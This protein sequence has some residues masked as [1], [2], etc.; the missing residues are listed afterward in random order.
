MS[1][2]QCSTA[3]DPADWTELR[4]QGHRMLDDMFDHLQGLR[5]QPVW[6]APPDDLRLDYRTAAPRGP[7]ALAEVHARFMSDIAPYSSGNAHPG[8]MGWVQGG[9][10]PVGMLAEMLAAGLNANL[11]GRDHMPIEVE[12][13]VG[14]WMSEVFGFPS[15]AGGLFLTGT[16]QA[17]FCAVLAARSR[18]LGAAVRTDG[19]GEDGRRLTAYVSR[20]AHGC[21]ARAMEMS[22]LGSGALRLIETD[23]HDRIDLS[24]LRRAIAADRAAGKTPFL[25]IGTAGTVGIGAID[26]LHGLADIAKANGIPFHVD[27]AFGALAILSPDLAPRLAG[28]ERADSLAFDFHKWGQVPYDAGYLLVRDEA[29]LRRTFAADDAYLRRAGRGLAGGDWWPCDLGPDLSRGFR[30]LK[31]WFTLR[32]YGLDAIGASIAATCSL[33]Q[34]LAQ[35]IESSPELELLAPVQLNIVCF[36]YRGRD[37]DRLNAQ[38]VERLQEGGRVAPSL[39]VV[40]GRTAIRAAIVNHRT[41]IQDIEALVAE[42]LALGRAA[43]TRTA[44][45]VVMKVQPPAPAPV[46]ATARITGLAVFAQMVFDGV[47]LATVWGGLVERAI[48]EPADPGALLDL[49]MILQLTG[50]AEQ[51]LNIQQQALDLTRLYRRQ[52]GD[53]SGPRILALVTAGDFMANTPLD[54]LLDGSDVQLDYL[55][56]SEDAPLPERLPEHD[57]AFFAVGE[58]SANR[59]TLAAMAPL[60][61]AWPRPMLNGDPDRI[62]ALTRDGVCAMSAAIPQVLSPVVRRL[63]R[64]DLLAIAGRHAELDRYLPGASFP[65]IIRPIDS[66]AGKALSKL[67]TAAQLAAYLDVQLQSAFYLTQFVDYAGADGLYRKQRIAFIDGQPFISHMAISEHWMVHYLNA[68]MGER[69]ERRDEEARFMAAFDQDFAV[70]HAEAF[71]AL[72]AA[73]GLDYFAIDCGETRDGR[74]LLFEADVAMIVH[75]MDSET[76][77][78]YKRPAMRKLL[79]RFQARLTEAAAVPSGFAACVA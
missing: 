26:D 41:E 55:Y 70:R 48:A 2:P 51:G 4:L 42:T 68:G 25:V 76:V 69:P 38:I 77:Y 46:D 62:A 37:P 13:Q 34:A 21:I 65:V 33:A 58:S 40:G 35:R 49:S 10:T 78:P 36:G 29:M 5:G 17:N 43:N 47:D 28:I 12:R 61:A 53:G 71:A 24:A 14:A 30:A 7:Q 22:G 67:D 57:A 9:G 19:V 27:G 6:Q 20:A 3:L 63:D 74:L 59:A 15:S 50:Q 73:F 44:L 23:S 52:F 64:A 45:Q 8:F 56:V 79:D 39:T 60:V 1:T 72:H 11:G 18:A 75:A 54:F 66:H 16:S 31:T 32:T